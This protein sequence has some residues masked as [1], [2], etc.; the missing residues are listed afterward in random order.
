MRRKLTKLD[1]L[2]LHYVGATAGR[3]KISITRMALEGAG[4]APATGL[5]FDKHR[6]YYYLR[7]K[8]MKHAATV[9]KQR[10][11]QG[12]GYSH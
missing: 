6:P 5:D 10:T 11:E 7:R 2:R 3:V 9:E 12:A 4:V 8:I 1:N